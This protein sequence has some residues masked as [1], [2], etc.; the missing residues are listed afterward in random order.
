MG[1]C[2]YVS[3]ADDTKTSFHPVTFVTASIQFA[4]LE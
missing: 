3:K 2:Y 1:K 4:I